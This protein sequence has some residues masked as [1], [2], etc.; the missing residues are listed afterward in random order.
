MEKERASETAVLTAVMRAAHPLIDSKPWVFEDPWAGV[1]VG[2]ETREAL[3]TV[4]ISIENELA[5]LSTR[6]LIHALLDEARSSVSI[7]SRYAEDELL[8]AIERGVSQYVILGSGF[9]SFAYR[10]PNSAAT[11]RIFEVDHP[12]TLQR[13]QTRLQ[14]LQMEIPPHVVF[15][16]L[17]FEEQLLFEGLRAA[18]FRNDQPAF[19]S[20]LGVTWF[21][22][23]E[24]IVQT[25]SQ[26]AA[27]ASG[28]EI[29][30]DFP[31][32]A[33]LLDAEAQQLSG[34]IES[35]GASRSEPIL[36]RFAPEDLTAL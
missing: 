35:M 18:G 26:V 31:L 19:F 22:T 16:P 29:V 4:L 9:D 21:L 34:V 1:F 13:K 24:A 2:I 8:K 30:F 33:L 10:R 14:E 32:P 12:A 20:W 6:A 28:N 23:K 3:Q 15:V 25:L 27:G 5:G 36:S 11:L 17:N 7:R